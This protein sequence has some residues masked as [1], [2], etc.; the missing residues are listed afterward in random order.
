MIKKT[1]EEI[2]KVI[3]KIITAAGADSRNADR[4]AEALISAQLAGIDTHGMWHLP[5]Y[6]SL[7]KSGGIIPTAW[8]EI[9]SQTENS[10]LVKGNFTFGHVTAKFAME[11]AIKKAKEHNMAIV[12]GVQV[13]HTGR[14]GEY[15]EMAADKNMISFMFSGGFSE[16]EPHSMP[17]GGAARVLHTNPMAMGFPA[18]YEPPMISDFAT[19]GISGVKIH[20]AK[21]KN[22]DLPQ[23]AIVDKEGRPTTKPDDFYAGGGHIPFGGHK[24]YALMLANEFLGRIFSNADSYADKRYCGP[25]CRNSG[26]TMIVF[27]SDMFGLDKDYRTYMDDMIKRIKKVPPAP[28]FDEVLIPGDIERK[29]RGKRLKDGIPISDEVWKATVELAVSLGIDDIK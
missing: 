5:G 26:F 9:V 15:V 2:T 17:Y 11:I 28:G 3:I 10:A 22:M 18:G 8:P 21:E 4:L 7:I 23:G 24:G 14:L 25:I 16:E 20:L 13:F 27:K 1:P 29:T 19:T 12:S 6:V